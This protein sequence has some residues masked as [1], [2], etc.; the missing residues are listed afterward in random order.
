M[1]LN[2]IIYLTT[3]TDQV[4]DLKIL[5]SEMMLKLLSHHKRHSLSRNSGPMNFGSVDASS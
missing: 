1:K 2:T 5:R 3:E 4:G